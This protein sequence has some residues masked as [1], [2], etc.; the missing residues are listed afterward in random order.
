[1]M[2][3]RNIISNLLQFKGTVVNEPTLGGSLEIALTV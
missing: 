3:I 1:M 2:R